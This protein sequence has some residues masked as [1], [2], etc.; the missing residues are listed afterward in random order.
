MCLSIWQHISSFSCHDLKVFLTSMFVLFFRIL[1]CQLLS[2]SPV[3]TEFS[4]IG[5][6][7]HIY[8]KKLSFPLD[9]SMMFEKEKKMYISIENIH[10]AITKYSKNYSK[11]VNFCANWNLFLCIFLFFALSG[12]HILRSSGIKSEN[13]IWY[14]SIFSP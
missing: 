5:L 1:Q 6:Y 9:F 13:G 12:W 11:N 14:T 2:P 7:C 8:R 10:L 4:S 3:D